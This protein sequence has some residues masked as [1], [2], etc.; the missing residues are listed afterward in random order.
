MDRIIEKKKWTFKRIATVL[1]VVVFGFMII[2]SLF[3][4]D[5]SSRLIVTTERL[6]IS[7]VKH[8]VFQEWI[9][10][11]GNVLP[12][13]TVY[14]DAIEGGRVEELLVEEGSL[15]TAGQPI[16]RI[17]NTNLFLD[18][19]Y[20]EADLFEQINGLRNTRLA[21]EQNR[22]ELQSTLLDLDYQISKQKRN[23]ER[24]GELVRNNMISGEEHIQANEEYQYLVARKLLTL[25]T[26]HQDSLFRLVQIE[27]LESSVNRM[28]SNLEIV[29]Q[30]LDN[31]TICAPITGQLTSLDADVGQSKSPGMRIG[32]IDV[33]DGFKVQCEIDEH[34]IARIAIGQAGNFRFAG[35]DY[36]LLVAKVYPQVR[37][38]RFTVDMNFV[39]DEPGC[40]R[41]GQTLRINLELGDPA[42]AVILRRGGFY[43]GS[44]GRW[45]YVLSGSMEYAI[46]RNI[47]LGRQNSEVFEILD[48]LEPGEQVITSSYENFLN[49]DKLVLKQD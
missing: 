14:I 2:L 13:K 42:E 33:M 47:K 45:V 11:N 20:R 40:I 1:I 7:E 22:L 37:D 8:D 34:Y 21:M 4:R 38:G 16:L 43:Q 30:K 41:H 29:K 5:G 44:G 6:T 23:Y 17:S 19:M 36:D 48:G 24:A 32:Q 25:D 28:Q 49:V 27:S 18:I 31:L 15:V 12:I 10:I 46:K 35:S 9:P 3:L 39:G 26:Y